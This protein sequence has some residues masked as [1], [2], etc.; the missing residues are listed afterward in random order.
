MDIDIAT[1]KKELRQEIKKRKSLFSKTEKISRSALIW[2]QLENKP[3]FL[4]AKVV[5]LYWSMDDEV[6]THDFIQKWHKE[7]SIILPCIKGDIL[8][9][10]KF[11][12]IENMET[13]GSF[14]LFEPTGENFTNLESIDLA[15]IPGIAFDKENN[16]MGRGKGYYDHFLTSVPVYK[17]GVCFH[18]QFLEFIPVQPFD[19]KMDEV[20]FDTF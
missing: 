20:I 17:I 9:L 14:G 3:V 16:R 18:F 19:I 2:P 11:S 7:R 13:N 15:I 10:K 8:E 5:M 12:G 1:Q 4:N 6:Y